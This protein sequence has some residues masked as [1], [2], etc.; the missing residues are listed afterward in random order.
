M[1]QL[2]SDRGRALGS[3]GVCSPAGSPGG[4]CK[5]LC[6]GVC[7]NRSFHFPGQALANYSLRSR[8]PNPC[9]HLFLSIKFYWHT[10]P[11]LLMCFGTRAAVAR[12][13]QRL[14][15]LLSNPFKKVCSPCL[16][17]SAD[18]SERCVLWEETAALLPE[19]PRGF[20]SEGQV[21]AQLSQPPTGMGCCHLC[22]PAMM[23]NG[24]PRT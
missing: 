18:E 19:G 3:R 23:R 1:L 12:R 2:R 16:R 4:C 5:S 15:S 10:A 20:H 6:M 21:G 9:H 24:F 14:K 22:F 17:V 8:G 7:V 11:P 13:P